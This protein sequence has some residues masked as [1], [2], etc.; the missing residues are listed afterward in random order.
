MAYYEEDRI[1]FDAPE[2][3]IDYGAN[4]RRADAQREQRLE[5]RTAVPEPPA[6]FE[7]APN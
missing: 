2:E 4:I 1:P 7:A 3:E 5:R 6:S